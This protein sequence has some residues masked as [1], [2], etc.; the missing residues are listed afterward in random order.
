MTLSI[1]GLQLFMKCGKIIN[2]SQENVFPPQEL[3]SQGCIFRHTE[4]IFF[5]C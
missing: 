4:H 2:K 1:G 5:F 3:F